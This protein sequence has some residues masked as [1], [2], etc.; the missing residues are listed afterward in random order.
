MKRVNK[1]RLNLIC[2]VLVV[3]S[4]GGITSGQT[5]SAST[6]HGHVVDPFGLPVPRVSLELSSAG[7]AT[8]FRAETD[9]EGGYEFKSLP[10][11]EYVAVI[12][13]PG[14]VTERQP[15]SLAKG[16]EL[17]LD[18]G[19]NVVYPHDPI[20]IGVSGSILKQDG[21]P[22]AGALV[23]VEHAFGRRRVYQARTDKSGRY[24]ID[25]PYPGQYI[26]SA[27]MPGFVVRATA[28]VL[29][30]TLPRQHQVINLTLLPL[31]SVG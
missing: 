22:L 10:A 28:V 20:P 6:I 29:P 1:P 2:A 18:F 4:T 16:A 31:R 7:Q 21:L 24:G 27:S 13:A 30:A 26:I 25:V 14:F 5:P 11:G 19:L 3:F 12:A 23:T 8:P 15:V 17:Q 9:H